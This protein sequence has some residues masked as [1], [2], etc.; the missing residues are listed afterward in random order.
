VSATGESRILARRQEE[1]DNLTGD[2]GHWE[3]WKEEETGGTRRNKIYSWLVPTE[4]SSTSSLVEGEI[5]DKNEKDGADQIPPHAENNI[6]VRPANSREPDIK[7]TGWEGQGGAKKSLDRRRSSVGGMLCVD[8]MDQ[9]MISISPVKELIRMFENKAGPVRQNDIPS[10][11][12]GVKC[13]GPLKPDK[14]HS[15]CSVE[16]CSSMQT[17]SVYIYTEDGQCD[18]S[19][20]NICS[21]GW[22]DTSASGS[23][24]RQTDSP[25]LKEQHA[26]RLENLLQ[27]PTFEK[28]TKNRNHIPRKKKGLFDKNIKVGFRMS[29][30]QNLFKISEKRKLENGGCDNF[31]NLENKTNTSGVTDLLIGQ[32]SAKKHCYKITNSLNS[33]DTASNPPRT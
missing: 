12:D 25:G 16:P 19:A 26:N 5:V 1:W 13:C 10:L 14:M 28:L 20:Q 6:F 11:R 7:V 9:D 2:A 22:C 33:G 21:M 31:E 17:D 15:S 32:S 18:N 3:E 30:I 24:D 23:P 8:S 27:S 29:T 4:P